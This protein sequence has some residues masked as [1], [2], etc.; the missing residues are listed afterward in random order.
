MSRRRSS[1]L[2]TLLSALGALAAGS[3]SPSVAEAAQP[4]FVPGQ[5]IVQWRGTTGQGGKAAARQNAGVASVAKLGDPRFQLVAVEPGQTV[6]EAIDRLRAEPAV[7]VAERDTYLTPAAI[8]D[9]PLFPQEWGLDNPGT[10][11]GGFSQ[12][13]AGADIHA[14]A[15]WS[16]TV[17]APAVIVADI[18]SGYRFDSPDLGPVAWTNAD[19][20][21]GNSVDDDGNGYVDD[22]HGFDFVGS[23]SEAPSQD[24]D[25]TDDNLISGGHG[26]HTAGT[27]AAAGDNGVGI[28]GV[29]QDVR[30]MPLRVCANNPATNQGGCPVSSIIAA[31]N[32]AA[33]NGA[34]VANISLGGT[35]QS[36]AELNAFA[37]NPQTLFVVAAGNDGQDHAS[38]P[39]YPCD[40]EPDTTGVTDAVDNIVCVG[41]TDQA[42]DL[43]SFSDW[44]DASVDLGAPGTEILSTY[45]A[46]PDLLGED[47]EGEDFE[48]RWLATGATG[49]FAQTDEAP[50][51]SSGISDSPGEAPVAGSVRES[52]LT[53]SVTVPESYGGCQFSGRRF[54]SLGGGT[55]NQKVIADGFVVFESNPAN[56]VGSQMSS[57]ST[58]PIT[59][60]GGRSVTLRFRYTAGS[61]PT[62]AS[63]VWLD[64]LALKCYAPLSTPPTYAFLEGTSM[65]AP[66]VTGA[67][68]L[69]FSLEPQADVDIVRQML[70]SEVDP[71]PSLAGKTVSGGRLDVAASL[72]VLEAAVRIPDPPQLTA[73]VPVSPGNIDEPKIVGSAEAGSTVRLFLGAGCDENIIGLVSAQKLAEGATVAVPDNSVSEISANTTGTNG[74]ISNCSEAISYE[75]DSLPPGQPALMIDQPSP[76]NANALTIG[77]TAE[78]GSSLAL[79][80]DDSCAGTP[81]VEG[82]ADELA[83]QGIQVSVADD[84]VSE[85]SIRAT[86]AAGNA[87]PCSDSVSYVEDSTPPLKPELTATSP[88]SPAAAAYP[89]ILGSAETDS[90]VAIYRGEFC[91]GLPA[92]AGEV[93]FLE[94]PGLEVYVPVGTTQS[95]SAIAS[96]AAGNASA[97]S[98]PISYTESSPPPSGPAVV[99][100]N[101]PL[102][103]QVPIA[104]PSPAACVVPKVT[105]LGLGRAKAA[106]AAARCKV[107]TI[108]K[109]PKRR[110]RRAAALVVKR[111]APAAGEDAGNGPVSLFLG[112]KP[113]RHRH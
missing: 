29:A 5:V 61:S 33:A 73:T 97:C 24:A 44:G 105:G 104:L 40:F 47:F 22:L 72:E 10:G 50:L 67:A 95:F 84:S 71:V 64:D 109:P 27:I 51:S 80:S 2:F 85:F 82:S 93:N 14:L 57:F 48:E 91:E 41:A 88:S 111:S 69:L 7:A 98:S 78:S 96:D 8:P 99:I 9:D 13:V 4:E 65:A 30:L 12:A 55:F 110:G 16:K 36:I 87:S 92:A 59:D 18:D 60:L 54:V 75:E 108:V 19:E 56:T 42:D 26:V 1:I 90:R 52:R 11:V 112:P 101:L 113:R 89:R 23:S 32:Y 107:G 20:I 39:H 58:V 21:G 37:S 28:S 34:R 6:A 49:G 74:K 15:A 66:H 17:G 31:V 94:S 79:Y 62:A 86:D 102:T 63:G 81:I 106:L 70:L 77:V 76:A 68:A 100:T 53:A 35:K 46:K 3:P 45:P 38:T 83:P 25:P 43:A 103:E